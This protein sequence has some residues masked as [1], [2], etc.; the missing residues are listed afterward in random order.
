MKKMIGVIA[1]VTVG[2]VYAVAMEGLEHLQSWR[3]GVAKADA[4]E[5]TLSVVCIGDSNTEAGAGYAPALREM[6]QGCYGE[7]GVGYHT[8][9]ERIVVPGAPEIKR[10][11]NWQCGRVGPEIPPTP[12][13]AP[14]L[15]WATTEDAEATVEVKFPL[16]EWGN[17]QD[18]LARIYDGQHRVRIHYQTGADKGSFGVFVGG[19]KV[20]R[21]DCASESAGYGITETFLADGFRIGDVR[22]NVTLLGFDGVRESWRQGEP[23][24]SGGVLVHALGRSWGQAAHFCKIEVETFKKLFEAL[25]PDIIMVVLGTNDMHN[26]GLPERYRQ[27]MATLIGKLQAAAPQ[28]GILVVSCPE[29]P[30]T[31]DGFAT[32]YRDIA[33]EVAAENRC[34]FWSLTDVVGER[35]RHW[36]REGFFADGLHYNR[37][38]G[39]LWARLLLRALEFDLNDLRHYPVLAGAAREDARPPRTEATL[40]MEFTIWRQNQKAATFSLASEDIGLALSFT[41]YGSYH[42]GESFEL[43]VSKPESDVVRQLVFGSK[44]ATL[45]EN[46]KEMPVSLPEPTSEEHGSGGPWGDSRAMTITI[47]WEVFGID[48]DEF[49]LEAAAVTG[50]P[51]SFDRLFATQPD[52]GAFRDNTQFALIKRNKATD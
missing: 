48:G 29:A 3:D 2:C 14:D 11:G 43:Y 8:F 13:F 7:R 35:S 12:W 6:L 36:T 28:T 39:S 17:S 15:L 9:G 45:H 34:A 18:R 52:R 37:L 21:V 32:A 20:L 27:N 50:T 49:L 25:K 26:E 5:K 30:Q 33:R 47:P 40:P 46:G 51:P 41:T 24:L 10:T 16:G 23:L 1:S 19:V 31:R 22:G 38:G 4:R 42:T 44:G